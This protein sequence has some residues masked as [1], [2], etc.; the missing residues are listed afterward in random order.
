MVAAAGNSGGSDKVNERETCNFSPARTS[1]VIAVGAYEISDN[2]GKRSGFSNYG[3]CT[4]IFAPG[5]GISSA[6]TA[7]D[8]A[9]ES[10]AGTSMA[11]PHVVG[12]VAIYLEMHPNASVAEVKNALIEASSKDVVGD[13]KGSPNRLLNINFAG[14]PPPD[15]GDGG[16]DGDGTPGGPDGFTKCADEGGTCTL[17]G[18]NEVAYGANGKFAKKSGVSGKLACD[19]TTFGDPLVGTYKACYFKQTSGGGSDGG[20]NDS[21]GT[22]GGPDGFTKCA[23]EG[24]NCS[25]SGTNEVAYGANGKF[26]KKSGVN[27]NIACNNE[28]FG[29]PI[30]GTYKACYYKQSSGGGNNDGGSNDGGGKSGGPDGYTKCADEGGTCALSGTRNVAYGANGKFAKKSGVSGN[31]AC[32]NATFGDP[33]FGTYKACY[34]Q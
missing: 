27:G 11:A 13:A 26:A 25:L 18:T 19:N 23:D 14:S 16:N 8:T 6:V 12:A 2:V 17:K 24:G 7:S 1:G 28:T 30:F 31:I 3:S 15:D 32:N 22:P 20:G 5:N 10:W 9:I 4:T 34:Y 33:I 29:D 21:D